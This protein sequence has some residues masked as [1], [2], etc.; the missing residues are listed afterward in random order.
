LQLK[1]IVRIQILENLS[2]PVE[3]AVR[4]LARDIEAVLG[5]EPEFVTGISEAAEL[6]IRF[7]EEQDNCAKRPEAFC[8]RFHSS[9]PYMDI[10][11]HDELGLVYGI[12]EFSKRYLG[13][14]PFWFWIDQP[15]KW[16]SEIDIDCEDYD[17]PAPKVRYRGW[18]VN[19]EVCLIVPNWLEG[20][21]S[22]F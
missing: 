13:I 14:Q 12:L 15:I 20:S 1:G 21:V 17:A 11:G 8:F 19:D 4:M 5:M 16:L 3:H 2:L 9:K 18:F 22:P 6:Q 10:I 7:A